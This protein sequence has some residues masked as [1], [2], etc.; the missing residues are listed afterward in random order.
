MLLITLQNPASGKVYANHGGRTCARFPGWPTYGARFPGWSLKPTHANWT[1]AEVAPY[2]VHAI[3]CF[4]FE[5][6]MFGGDWPVS[7]LATTYRRWVDLVDLVVAG[8]SHGEKRAS[9]AT[10]Q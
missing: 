9:I 1:N 7:E 5:R 4:G 10:T 6:V 3:D 2:I 8:A